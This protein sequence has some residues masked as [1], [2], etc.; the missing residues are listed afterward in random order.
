[1]NE[2][3]LDPQAVSDRLSDLL[4]SNQAIAT[5]LAVLFAHNADKRTLLDA[6]NHYLPTAVRQQLSSAKSG[7][8]TKQLIDALTS[9]ATK[10]HYV[11]PRR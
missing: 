10:G 3:E 7:K 8:N 5:A 9:A 1:M 11:H 6:F 2:P 4:A